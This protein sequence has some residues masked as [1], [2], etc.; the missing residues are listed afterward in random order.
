MYVLDANY[1]AYG[2]LPEILTI[3]FSD[4]SVLAISFLKASL[5]R[6]NVTLV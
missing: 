5:I 4:K 2:T 6:D 3:P 1:V